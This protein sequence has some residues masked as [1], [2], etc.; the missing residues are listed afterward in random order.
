M[1]PTNFLTWL[2]YIIVFFFSGSIMFCQMIPQRILHVDICAMSE[3]HNPGASNVFANCGAF[4]GTIC[5]SLDVMKGFFPIF[6][7]LRYLNPDHMLFAA[8]LAAPVLG[9]AVAPLNHFHGGKCI[10]TTFGEMLALYPFSRIGI[11]LAALYILFSTVVRIPSHRIRSIAAFGIFGAAAGI[12]LSLNQQYSVA[13]GC[14][15]IS[16][17]AIAKHSKYFCC[18]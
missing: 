16:L 1:Y 15:L 8:V 5:L 13:L 14:V 18:E 10:A 17:T 6:L 7:S 11:L 3:D 12:L 9:H 4:W 2:L